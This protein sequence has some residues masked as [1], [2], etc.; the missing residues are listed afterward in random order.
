[1]P[2]EIIVEKEPEAVQILN[3]AIKRFIE[4]SEKCQ[5]I[6]PS[7]ACEAKLEDGRIFQL[8]FERIDLD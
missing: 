6:N 7:F 4:Y 3:D 2:T 1:M 8:K 5:F